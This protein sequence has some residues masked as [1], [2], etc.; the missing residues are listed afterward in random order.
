[1][2]LRS[3]CS[4]RPLKPVLWG[5]EPTPMEILLA[6]T[7]SCSQYHGAVNRLYADPFFEKRENWDHRQQIHEFFK[8]K[9]WPECLELDV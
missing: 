6:W 4:T 8:S 7:L 9:T 3:H 2:R 1:M 5:I